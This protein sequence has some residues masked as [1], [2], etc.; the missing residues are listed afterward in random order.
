LGFA[1]GEWD[2]LFEGSGAED[3]AFEAIDRACD[4]V[5][6]DDVTVLEVVGIWADDA[7]VED[8]VADDV[9]L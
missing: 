9:A 3:V 6:V 7:K 8:E 1:E 4:A 5:V 2:E